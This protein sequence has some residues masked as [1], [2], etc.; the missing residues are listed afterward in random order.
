MGFVSGS[1]DEITFDEYVAMLES[2][3]TT[4]VGEILQNIQT[5]INTYQ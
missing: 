2:K 1:N 3:P 4:L 5:C